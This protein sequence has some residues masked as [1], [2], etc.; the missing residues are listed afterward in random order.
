[1][2]L[3]HDLNYHHLLYFWTVAHE[4][5]VAAACARLNLTQ[6]TISMQIRKLERSLGQQLFRRSGRTL[7]LTETGQTVYRYAD[8][9][10]SLG[11]E[12]TQALGGVVA[13]RPMRLVVG[14]PDAM[15][16]L[17]T[18]RLLQPVLTMDEPVQLVCHEA[19]LE[20]LLA[21]LAVHR[22]D[23]LLSDAP[24]GLDTRVKAF[25]HP[26]G[27]CGVAFC[28]TRALA[29]KYRSKF[30]LS[31]GEAPL[32][33][34]TPNTEL[35]RALDQWFDAQSLRP[36]IAGEFEDSA[37]LKEFGHGGLGLFP[38][39]AVVL[40]Q[41]MKQYDVAQVGTLDA[42]RTRFYAISTQRRVRHPAVAAICAAA[43]SSFLG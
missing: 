39:P 38:V 31:L 32:L 37:L 3:L 4:G 24:L 27:D 2:L 7:V 8:E 6:P 16:K 29:R 41:V 26:L 22:Y 21:D 20:Q 36:R 18:Y 43:R 14:V 40:S 33:L 9:I 1:V 25:S 19:K 28:G 5:T 15:P 11:R 30:P 12:L 17:V 10:F 13:G 35:R 23:V 34:P 42:V